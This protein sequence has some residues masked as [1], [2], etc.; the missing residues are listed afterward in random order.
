MNMKILD[1]L[2]KE[3]AEQLVSVDT[4]NV[5]NKSQWT[6]FCKCAVERNVTE[7]EFES[8]LLAKLNIKAE[9]E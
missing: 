9:V 3:M 6:E 4:D 5:M 1:I 8:E 7:E 2:I